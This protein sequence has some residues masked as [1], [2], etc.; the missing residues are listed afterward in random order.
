MVKPADKPN[1]PGDHQVAPGTKPTLGKKDGDFDGD[2]SRTERL[3]ELREA[4][5]TSDRLFD[6]GTQG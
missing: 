3:T 6:Q 4:L 5:D 1:K 2:D